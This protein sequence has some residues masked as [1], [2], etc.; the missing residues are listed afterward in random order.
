MAKNSLLLITPSDRRIFEAKKNFDIAGI[1][2][3]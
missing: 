2:Y 3:S 1:K